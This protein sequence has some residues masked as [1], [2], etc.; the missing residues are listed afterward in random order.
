[1][2]LLR[3]VI[4]VI[5]AG[6]CELLI[7]VRF[8]RVLF[9]LF[10][11]Y[12]KSPNL[13][14]VLVFLLLATYVTIVYHECGHVLSAWLLRY[15]FLLFLAGPLKIERTRHGIRLRLNTSLKV[16]EGRA[17]AIPL[18]AQHLR[19]R[20]LLFFAG[21][22]LANLV[23]ALILVMCSFWPGFILP[24]AVVMMLRIAAFIAVT[25]FVGNLVPLRT[26]DGLLSD[27]A[28]M[29]LLLKGGPPLERRRATTL[30]WM[31]VAAG[32][33]PREWDIAL[34]QEAMALPDGTPEDVAGCSYMYYWSLDMGDRAGARGLL[35]RMLAAHKDVARYQR[36][37]LALEAAYFEARYHQNAGAARTW[38]AQTKGIKVDR[39]TRLRVEAAVLLAEGKQEEARI[40][41]QRGLAVAKNA[42][43]TGT[44][45]REETWLREMLGLLVS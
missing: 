11:P 44:E 12:L 27:G 9:L 6:A 20:Q 21:G 24:I 1:M 37:W 31:A 13:P 23:Q 15:R 30:L 42:L 18:D 45:R 32:Q 35:E 7:V 43:Y 41:I 14:W 19:S 26:M 34:L 38:L 4:V 36:R 8:R 22:P 3:F 17:S 5:V 28:N 29:L 25:S 16:F 39:C 2:R 10:Y 40:C 33:R